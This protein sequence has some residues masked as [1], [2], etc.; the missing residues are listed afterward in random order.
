MEDV[1]KKVLITGN[2]NEF[3]IR[4]VIAKLQNMNYEVHTCQN[5]I[6]DITTYG[7]GIRI[8]VLFIESVEQVKDMLVFLKDLLFDRSVELGIV[9]ERLAIQE[10]E[11]YVQKQNIAMRFTRPTDAREIVEGIEE[12][13]VKAQ[14]R[15]EKKR[16]L[17]VDDDPEFLRRVQGLLHNH[18]KIFLASSPTAGMMILSKHRV[19]LVIVDY[20][21]PVING[22]KFM[23]ALQLESDT[24]DIPVM[25]L[26]SN[27]DARSV[28]E[29]LSAGAVNYIRKQ[30]FQN[31]LT[32][33][34]SDFFI[35][36][37]YERKKGR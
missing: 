22:V 17:L 12:L 6:N 32:T 20:M 28:T 36:K 31:E 34:I 8:Y 9:G 21:M 11:K 24:K 2:E 26:S 5:T 35:Q 7:Q 37:D 4:S 23:Q 10:A 30:T 27:T 29:A 33:A 19:D 16:I 25:F 3:L 15:A 1:T 18:Y 13:S 14:Q